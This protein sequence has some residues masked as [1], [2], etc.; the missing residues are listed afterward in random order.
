MNVRLPLAVGAL[1]L[2]AGLAGCSSS[3]PD[4]ASSAEPSENVTTP[5]ADS[6]P[7][8]TG[9]ATPEPSEELTCAT[10]IS[11][12]TVEAL[13]AQGWTTKE[14]E[15]QIGE[16]PMPDGL[17]CMWADFSTASDHGQMYAY[18]PIDEAT[19]TKAQQ[20]LDDAGWIRSN[21]ASSVYYTEDPEFA[22]ATDDEGYGLTYQFSG[23]WVKFADTKQ[24]LLLINEN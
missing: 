14:K 19:A 16:I 22:I 21:D 15:F 4:A 23:T 7:A 24:G 12:T 13:T 11:Q 17:M 5:K 2:A 8:P 18:S 3:T 20:S 9:S 10:L 6:S 1:L